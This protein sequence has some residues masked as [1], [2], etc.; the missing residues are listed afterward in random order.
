MI[1]MGAG[2]I[3]EGPAGVAGLHPTCAVSPPLELTGQTGTE[4][5]R[6]GGGGGKRE[7]E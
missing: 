2:L 3:S 6:G 1:C 4:P 7:R 5:G